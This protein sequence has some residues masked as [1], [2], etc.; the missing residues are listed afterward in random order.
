MPPAAS[1]T[2]RS[3]PIGSALSRI[4]TTLVVRA[5]ACGFALGRGL[6][7]AFALGFRLGFGLGFRLGFAFA[8]GF[9]L[10]FAFAFGFATDFFATGCFAFA[11]AIYFSNR[12]S[13]YSTIS[14][15]TA[16]AATVSGEAR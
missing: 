5:A 4:R 10:G 7:F 12:S 16:D 15:A 14:P 13:R 2:A 11:R 3:A 9:R 6:G 8:L 1:R